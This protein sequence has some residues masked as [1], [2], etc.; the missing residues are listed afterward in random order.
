MG[1]KLGTFTLR[2][3]LEQ[4]VTATSNADSSSTGRS[5]VLS[6]TTLRFT[7]AS[8]WENNSAS[9]YGYGIFRKTLSGQDIYDAQGRVEG[10]L[11]LD[12]DHEWRAIGTLGYEAAPE[13]ATSPVVIEGTVSQPLRQ[14]F[15]G[16]IGLQKEVGKAQLGITGAAT[17][18]TYGDADQSTG[19]VISQKDRNSTLY[20][21]TL[22]GGYEISPALTPFVELEG[23]RRVFDQSVD[24]SGYE[25]S[26][27]RVAARA[28]LA[29]D[30]GDKLRGE[31]SGG[32]VRENFDDDRLASIS[33]ATVNADVKWSPERGT[34]VDLTGQTTLEDT[35]SAGE[36]GS[37][38]YSGKVAVEREVRSDLTVGA[39]AGIDWRDYSG[40]SDHDLIYSAEASVTWWM[41]RYAGITTRARTEKLT[42][43]LP[44]RAETTNSIYLGLTVQK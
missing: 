26:S 41:N 43:T 16:S 32:W 30:Q 42:S 17:R 13:S 15:D 14:S 25:R 36:S 9:A 20:T 38:L 27:N 7:A 40:T 37:I 3:A 44:G 4:G 28:G 23:G 8:D 2:P 33:G 18:D 31:L 6:Q 24:D 1:I 5:A 35:T 11:N 12:L 19:G 29:F 39:A 10:T 22:R 21:A 34:T